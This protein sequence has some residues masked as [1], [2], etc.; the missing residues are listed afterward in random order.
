MRKTIQSLLMIFV[1]LISVLI[2]AQPTYAQNNFEMG[3]E[4]VVVLK[5]NETLTFTL[6]KDGVNLLPSDIRNWENSNPNVATINDFIISTKEYGTTVLIGYQD[7]EDNED[8]IRIEVNVLE[9]IAF[10]SAS[11]TIDVEESITVGV[12][13]NPDAPIENLN[14]T[15]SSLDDTIAS[16]NSSG[17]IVGLKEGSTI[18]EA[19]YH[20]LKAQLEVIVKNIPDF[21]FNQ[22][23]LTMN[24]FSSTLAPYTISIHG[25]RDDTILWSSDNE[26]VVTINQAGWIT[27][28]GTGQTNITAQVLNQEYILPI[29]VSSGVIDFNISISHLQLEQGQSYQLEWTIEPAS[30]SQL[31]VTWVSS[32]PSVATVNNG[33]VSAKGPGTT[34]ISARVDNIVRE[35]EVQVL[36]S[37]ENISVLP[38]SLVLAQNQESHLSVIYK[39]SNTTA[40]KNPVFSSA[41]PSIA[42]VDQNGNVRGVSPGETTIFI[43]DLGFSLTV[44]VTVTYQSD[45]S[46]HSILIGH[47][48]DADTVTFDLSDIDDPSQVILE[49]PFYEAFSSLDEITLNLMMNDELL[50]DSTLISKGLFLNRL[51]Q[52]KKVQLNVYKASGDLLFNIDFNDFDAYNT[53]L[54]VDVMNDVEEVKKKN[55]LDF[56]VKIPFNLNAQTTIRVKH[57]PISENETFYLYLVDDDLDTQQLSNNTSLTVDESG[58]SQF[59]DIESGLYLISTINNDMILGDLVIYI[60]SGLAVVSIL[61]FVLYKLREMKK[62][63]KIKQEREYGLD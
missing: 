26:A 14:V 34:I 17:Q 60:V 3:S 16:V 29:T 52:S 39:P 45:S 43:E 10:E 55:D 38:R 30:H 9:G 27:A 36:I 62:E 8:F 20:G 47:F 19:D 59:N 44:G 50:D 7:N 2:D 15:Y 42:T 48:L 18:I 32:K 11:V 21:Q 28:V 63:D 33:V 13:T 51:Y 4:Q 25:G 54:F 35:I 49:V 12:V 58:M 46:G 57:E 22:T 53:N 5:R 40:P 24:L 6:V 31:G 1:L 61:G 37:V 41:D 56:F 23:Q